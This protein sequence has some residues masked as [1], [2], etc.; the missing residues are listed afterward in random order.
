LRKNGQ[1]VSLLIHLDVTFEEVSARRTK[2]GE[3]F[4]ENDRTDNTPEAIKARQASYD[5]TITSIKE[6]F[7]SKN[8][9][10]EVDGNRPVEPIFEDICLKIDNLKS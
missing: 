1:P 5:E 3:S 7:K 10:F 2:L 4:Q 8:I 9:L 6:Y